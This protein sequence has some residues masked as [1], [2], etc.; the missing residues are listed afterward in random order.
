VATLARTLSDETVI[1]GFLDGDPPCA[2]R[3]SAWIFEVLRHPRFGLGPDAE[4]VAQQV[5]RNLIGAFRDGRFA[6]HAS[7]R[8]Y[9][10]R[11]TQHAA[12]DRLRARRT[13]PIDV[14]ID[15]VDEPPHPGPSPEDAVLR[16]ERREVFARILTSLGD[17]CR[18][19]FH[20]IVFE[21]L[22]YAEIARRLQAT[23]GAIKVR[24]LRCREKAVAEYKS[25]TSGRDHRPLREEDV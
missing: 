1:R 24:A 2:G 16:R 4:D 13:K 20:L 14:S 15:A 10:W 23:E 12:I 7:L 5:R 11:V 17:D 25:V 18:N 19:L 22:S 21:E 3:I 6:G 9:V 8:T